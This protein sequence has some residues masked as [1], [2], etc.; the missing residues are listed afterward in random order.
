MKKIILA[1]IVAITTM[2]CSSCTKEL[3]LKGTTWTGTLSEIDEDE[4]PPMS[5]N[6]QNTLTF[7]SDKEGSMVMEGKVSMEEDGEQYSFPISINYKFTYTVNENTVSMAGLFT[8]MDGDSEKISV[9]AIANDKHDE[10]TMT[11]EG[12]KLVFKKK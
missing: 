1:T 7:S 10:L 5:I 3:D 9:V 6:T 12:K 2:L 11:F 4:E 8:S